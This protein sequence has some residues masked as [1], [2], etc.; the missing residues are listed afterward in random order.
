LPPFLFAGFRLAAMIGF[1]DRHRSA[2]L[3]EIM[4]IRT[5]VL[6][7]SLAAVLVNTASAQSGQTDLVKR[8]D[9]LVNGI[10]TCGNCHTPKG[11]PAAIAGKDFSGG[12]SWDEPPFKVTAPNITP[13]KD[14]GIGTWTDADIKKMMRT[15]MRPNNVHVAMIMPTGFYHIMTDRDLNAVVAYLRTLKPVNNKVADPIYKMPQTENVLPGGEK[16]FTVGMMSDKIKKGFYLATIAH[17]ME[18]HT[19]ME[20]GVRRWDTRLGAGGFEFPGPW[21]VSVSRN[22][23][24]SKTKG[25]GAWTDDE[26]K[27][28]ITAGF[29]K[30]G[31]K[32]KPPMGYQY[33]ATLTPDDLNAVVA[34]LRTVPAKE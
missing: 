14:T 26:I 23:T 6:A 24:S 19:Q 34:Y 13:D 9:Y 10:M 20:K 32:L 27:R 1:N 7:T 28:A 15:G 21:G 5:I 11:P 16:P 18:C 2:S 31:S 29:S 3:G 30:D 17:C 33:Y 12:L 4:A 8:G 22:I 25:I